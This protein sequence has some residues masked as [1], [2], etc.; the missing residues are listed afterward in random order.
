MKTRDF[1]LRFLARPKT[2]SWDCWGAQRQ[3]RTSSLRTKEVFLI[4]G[5]CVF[6][7][8]Q[9][10]LW[11]KN[12][13]CTWFYKQSFACLTTHNFDFGT[14]FSTQKNIGASLPS[15]M[16]WAKFPHL[17]CGSLNFFHRLGG[18]TSRYIRPRLCQGRLHL[19]NGELE[20]AQRT[21]AFE[22]RPGWIS[23]HH[24]G[25]FNTLIIHDDWMIWGYFNDRTPV[26]FKKKTPYYMINERN[27]YIY[28]Y[29][30]DWKLWEHPKSCG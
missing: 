15:L 14:C 29:N 27:T 2:L 10:G 24:H 19:M 7:S 16:H 1:P 30:F 4:T 20:D 8:P 25:C 13:D 5:K 11:S 22:S 26:F 17:G 23:S 21:E 28:T 9:T 6:F 18:L 12:W 3:K